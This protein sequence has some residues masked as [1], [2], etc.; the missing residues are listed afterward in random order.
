MAAFPRDQFDE[1]PRDIDRVGAHRAPGKPGRGWVAFAWA[2]LA[3]GVLVVVGLFALAALD[4]RFELPVFAP[5]TPSATPSETIVETADP[6]TDPSTLDD[7]LRDGLTIAVLNAT[8]TEGL[9]NVAGDQIADAGWPNPSRAAAD[10]TDDTETIVYYSSEEY[11]GVARGIMEL[12]GAADVSLSDAF[13]ATVVTVVLGSD[14]EPPA[15][16]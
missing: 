3:T 1:I 4:S 14:Y 13:P 7:A 9:S 10:V 11:E 2:A 8:G 5:E 6:V 12:I 16:G 15:G